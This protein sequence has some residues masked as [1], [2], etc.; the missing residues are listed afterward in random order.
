ML[1]LAAPARAKVDRLASRV[2]EERRARAPRKVKVTVLGPD[3]PVPAVVHVDGQP[4]RLDADGLLELSPGAH[5]LSAQ[6]DGFHPGRTRF[7]AQDGAEIQLT[8]LPA[9]SPGAAL[10]VA[11]WATAGAGL[12]AVAAGAA[13]DVQGQSTVD[14]LKAAAA[15][16]DEARYERL[17]ADAEGAQVATGAT[18]GVAAALLVVGGVLLYLGYDAPVQAA[19]GEA[20][21]AVRW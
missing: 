10:R 15:S 20:A 4:V 7:E 17:K 13:L 16:G 1:P 18:Y 19:P 8:L 12:V 2:A 9:E 3:G 5:G 6:A 11:G 14:D 21:V